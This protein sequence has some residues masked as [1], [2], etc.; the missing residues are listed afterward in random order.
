MDQLKLPARA[1][2]SYPL[3]VRKGSL[4]SNRVPFAL[5]ISR[6][7]ERNEFLVQFTRREEVIYNLNQRVR[8]NESTSSLIC[9]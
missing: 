8:I 5:D 9:F 2:G 4:V 6:E 3:S 7:Q 1:S